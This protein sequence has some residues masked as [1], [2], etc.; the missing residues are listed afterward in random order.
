MNIAQTIAQTGSGHVLVVD[1]DI[2]NR[3]YACTLLNFAGFRTDQA[4][5][6]MEALQCITKTSYDAVILDVIMP[7]LDGYAA[8]QQI[9]E[10]NPLLPVIMV[11]SL[12]MP[13]DIVRCMN[14]GA[15][16]FISKPYNPTVLMAR[17][18]SAIEKKRLTD[19][20]DD[21]EQVLFTLAKM[22]ETRDGCTGDHCDRLMEMGRSFGKYLKLS[23]KELDALRKAG[24][25][26][27]IGK[28]GIP[29]AILQK[30]GPLNAQEWQVMKTHP[31]IGAQLCAPLRSTGHVLEII[32]HHHERWNGN[33]YPD[34]LSGENIPYLAR[35]FQIIDAFDALCHQR[36]YKAAMSVKQALDTLRDETSQ[37]LWDPFLMQSFFTFLEQNPDALQFGPEQVQ[38]Y[39][40]ETIQSV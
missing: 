6:G 2:G 22:V 30:Q 27:D 36:S 33:G 34:G 1:D 31:L 8:L 29:D 40:T 17:L 23:D 19:R 39:N 18:Q 7:R 24:V 25:L 28:L 14:A 21:T 9:R 15:A 20:L 11:T 13:A 12:D 3:E 16:D 4:N 5:D 32:R 10:L 35:V 38:T 37:G 26:H